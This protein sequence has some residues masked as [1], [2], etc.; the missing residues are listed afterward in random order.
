[1]TSRQRPTDEKKYLKSL[2]ETVG[3]FL[4]ALDAVMKLPSTVDRGKEV[5]ILANALEMENDKARYFG[6]GID[7]RTDKKR[8]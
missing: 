3:Q 6:L 8:R 4:V 2:T 7:Y 1:M 5:A